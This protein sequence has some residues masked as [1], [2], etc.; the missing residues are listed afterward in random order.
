[1]KRLIVI[2]LDKRSLDGKIGK[3][4]VEIAKE[5]TVGIQKKLENRIS[6][7]NE[8]VNKCVQIEKEK[9]GVKIKKSTKNKMISYKKIIDSLKKENDSLRK[10]LDNEKEKNWLGEFDIKEGKNIQAQYIE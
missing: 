2:D 6:K 10:K 8:L 4:M 5:V 3:K 9:E 7:H 1:M